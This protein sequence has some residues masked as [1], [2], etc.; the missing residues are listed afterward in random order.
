M[1]DVHPDA[2]R[3]LLHFIYV[4]APPSRRREHEQSAAGGVDGELTLTAIPSQ[5]LDAQSTHQFTLKLTEP[6]AG[7]TH[8]RTRRI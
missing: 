7:R 3:A 1:E 5:E 4:G 8:S 2:F 6:I